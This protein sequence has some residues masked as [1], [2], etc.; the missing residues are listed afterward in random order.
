MLYMNKQILQTQQLFITPSRGTTNLSYGYFTEPL[1]VVM[2]KPFYSHIRMSVNKIR[3]YP[4]SR[5]SVL[6][7]WVQAGYNSQLV[8]PSELGRRRRQWRQ[9]WALSRY[10]LV[11]RGRWTQWGGERRNTTA[12]R[13]TTRPGVW[14]FILTPILS[15]AVSADVVSGLL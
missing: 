13:A 8:R 6:I 9:R 2:L 1:S 3:I 7:S 11:T 12:S 5:F 10:T 14:S 15:V 4:D